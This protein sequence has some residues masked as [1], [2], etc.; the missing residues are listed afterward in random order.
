M[1]QALAARPDST[2]YELAVHARQVSRVNL[3]QA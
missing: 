2:S 3:Q 1:I